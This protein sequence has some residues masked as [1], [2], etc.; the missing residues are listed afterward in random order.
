MTNLFKQLLRQRGLDDSFLNP[1]YEDLF[2]P[3]ELKGMGE[4]MERIRIAREANE[5]IIIYCDYDADGVTSSTLMRDALKYYG[6]KKVESVP[7][8]E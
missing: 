3:E 5:K 4:A 6:C 8:R 7:Y 2:K 1:R